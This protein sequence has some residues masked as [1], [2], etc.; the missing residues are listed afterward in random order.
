LNE[1]LKII[2][3]AEIDKL[4]ADLQAAQKEVNNL[5]DKG[6]SGFQKFGKAAGAA[7]KAVAAGLAAAGAAIVAGGAALVG[8]AESTREYRTEQAKLV[9]AFE[10]AGGSAETAKKTYNDLYRVLGDTGQATEAANLLAQLTTE[11][12]ALEEWTTI[13]QGAYATFGDSLPVES[14]AEAA[15]ETAKTGEITGA[16]ADALNWAGVSEAEF[17][18]ELFWCNSEAEREKLIRGTLNG[19][20]G[21]AA[22][23]YEENAASILAANEAQA[24]LT[25]SLA[26]LGAAVEPIVTIFKA[27]FATTLAELVPHMTTFAQGLQDVIKGVE[28]GAEKMKEGL[29][30]MIDAIVTKIAELLPSM[31]T[32]GVEVITAILESL[33]ANFPKI[34]EA[35]AIAIPLVISALGELIPKATEALLSALP[36]LVDVV[37]KAAAQILTTLGTVLPEILKQIV[38]ILP[39]IIDSIIQNIPVLLK[40]AIQFL[41]AIVQA[42]PEI[43]PPLIEAIPTIIDSIIDVVLN[44]YPLLVDGAVELLFALV[45]AVPQIIPPLL[46]ALPKIISSLVDAII[47]AAPMLLEASGKMFFGIVTALF[48]I[49]PELLKGAANIVSTIRD[50]LVEKL[51]SLFKFKWELPKIKLPKFAVTPAGW[52]IGDLLKGVI[53]KLGITWNARGG[54]FDS[55]TVFGYGGSLQ[56]IGEDGAEA[57]VPLENNLEWLDKLAGMLSNRLSGNNRPIVLQVDGKTFARTTIDVLNADTRQRGKLGLN[58]V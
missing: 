53:P 4:K 44:S 27:E 52:K 17:A 36:L 24:L 13:C 43:I 15:N 21:E 54:V 38:D 5:S 30:G 34:M 23:G 42:I 3:T 49:V 11:E 8:L 37:F 16:L 28:G 35:I 57:V 26:D 25:Q 48:N 31:L 47:K 10:T 18:E 14:L 55:P 56:G 40:A 12:K 41:M 2:I 39:Q 1:E 50:S 45:D 29:G 6:G 58:I 46:E 32:L 19:L 9:T 22:A 20:Y 51:K 7:G 33:T